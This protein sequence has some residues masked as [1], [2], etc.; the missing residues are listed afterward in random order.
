MDSRLVTTYRCGVAAR[1]SVAMTLLELLVVIA[2]ISLLIA[3]V[4][5]GI[6]NIR[7]GRDLQVGASQCGDQFMIARQTA[8]TRNCPVEVRIYTGTETDSMRL[9]LVTQTGATGEAIHAAY[10]LPVDIAISQNATWSSLLTDAVC[11]VAG[12]DTF[13]SYRSF[14]YQPSG[15]TSLAGTADPTLTLLYRS[16]VGKSVLPPNFCTLQI[17]LNSGTVSFYRPL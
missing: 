2:I 3:L 4:L 14:R 11:G 1:S 13:G 9:Y 12:S 16:D 8:W 7:R 10:L 6:Q 15:S 5:P 17:N